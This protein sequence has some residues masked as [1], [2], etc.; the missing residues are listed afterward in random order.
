MGKQGE[1]GR[2]PKSSPRRYIL[3][4]D[5]S[6]KY[7]S[8]FR[9]QEEFREAGTSH[10][11]GLGLF[12]SLIQ[13]Q[14]MPTITSTNNSIMKIT[15]AI[16]GNGLV[17][18]IRKVSQNKTNEERGTAGSIELGS[19]WDLSSQTGRRS[20]GRMIQKIFVSSN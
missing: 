2:G 4:Q 14:A 6:E 13:G 3:K 17:L 5:R 8:L 16:R 19:L 1:G 10:S 7:Q 12:T 15:A 11:N 20:E 9:I 18:H